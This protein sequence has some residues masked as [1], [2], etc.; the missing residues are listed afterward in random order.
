MLDH[1]IDLEAVAAFEPDARNF[2]DLGA[3]VAEVAGGVRETILFP[4]GL[5]EASGIR[6]FSSGSG[7]ASSLDSQGDTHVQVVA[8]D[9]VLPNFAP[10]FVKLDI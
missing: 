9:D 8:L 5:A 7:A 2:R 6:Q 1:G 3:A 4:C 10:T